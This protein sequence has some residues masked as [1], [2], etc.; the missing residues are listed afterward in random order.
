MGAVTSFVHR[1]H[2]Y[3]LLGAVR[4]GHGEERRPDEW[5]P[6]GYRYY[7]GPCSGHK[8]LSNATPLLQTLTTRAHGER[9]SSSTTRVH[10]LP[11]HE[12]Q[13]EGEKTHSD[14]SCV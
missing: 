1:H 14:C 2:A 12:E 7:L 3:M 10:S 4:Q 6:Y 11:D 5:P 13:L 9:H 8:H